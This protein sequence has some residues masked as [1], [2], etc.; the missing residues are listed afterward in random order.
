MTKKILAYMDFMCPTG[1]GTVAH[2]VMDRLTPWFRKNDIQVDVASLNFYDKHSEQY[3]DQVVAINPRIFAR[4]MDDTYYRDGILKMLQMGEYDLLWAMNDV[5]VLGP[6]SPVLRHLRQQKQFQKQKEFKMLMYTPIDSV[7]FARYFKDLDIWDEVYTYTDYG[8][9]QAENAFYKV[10][11]RKM[12]FGIIPHGMNRYEF[13]PLNDKQSLRDKYDLP[14]DMFIFGNINKNQPRK[15]IGTSILAFAEFKKWFEAQPKTEKMPSKVGLYLHCYHSD[16][17]GIKIHVACERVGLEI[18]KD[19]FLPIE[20]KYNSNSYSTQEMNEVYNCLDA[21]LSTTTAEGWGLTITEAM[22]V[23]LPIICG[24]HTS[25]TE[26]TDNGE[27]V[28][29]VNDVIPH[30]QID[31]AENVRLK[32]NPTAVTNQMINVF[33]DKLSKSKNY[34]KSYE[35]K[36]AEYDWDKIADQWKIAIKRLLKL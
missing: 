29:I 14:K 19:V 3:N 28:Y 24:N 25:L 11:R 36:F 22:S 21:F 5:P 6:M 12:K 32:L 13:Q 2:N 15:D 7:P 33:N 30:F 17:S 31:D 35:H 8:K 16:K 18:G 1:F 4:S 9:K 26:I 34:W 20:D 10:N 27:L 23:G